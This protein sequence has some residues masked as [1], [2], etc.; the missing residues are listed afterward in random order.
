MLTKRRKAIIPPMINKK[1]KAP[2]KCDI[3]D[4]KLE[5]ML[6]LFSSKAES[7][8]TVSKSFHFYFWFCVSLTCSLTYYI[9][10]LH[11]HDN[12]STFRAAA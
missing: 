9:N 1:A 3:K 5:L 4:D 6:I 7:F 2:V 12:C 10:M 11:K 8:L